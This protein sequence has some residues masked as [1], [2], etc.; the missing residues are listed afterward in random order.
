MSPLVAF[1]LGLGGFKV[2]ARIG[3]IFFGAAHFG[4]NRADLFVRFGL[5]GGEL[6]VS[7]DRR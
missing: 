3:D 6:L 7:F 4:G 1:E 5:N 2:A